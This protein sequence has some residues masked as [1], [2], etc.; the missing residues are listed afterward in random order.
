MNTMKRLCALVLITTTLI[1]A[2][3]ARQPARNQPAA[4][5]RQQASA[6]AISMD[7]TTNARTRTVHSS[8]RC[9][10]YD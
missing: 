3:P 1:E 9:F 2:V 5:A 10:A 4:P 7:Q 8:I 6:D